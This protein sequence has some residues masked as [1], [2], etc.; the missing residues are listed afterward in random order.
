MKPSPLLLGQEALRTQL[1]CPTSP[2]GL[3]PPA[4]LKHTRLA[5]RGAEASP[6]QLFPIMVLAK[7]VSAMWDHATPHG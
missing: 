6:R 3:W 1:L 4:P 7:A 5:P 2:P